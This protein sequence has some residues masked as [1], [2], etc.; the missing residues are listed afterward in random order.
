M[1]LDKMGTNN[2][3]IADAQ[4]NKFS[5]S[6]LFFWI[7]GSMLIDDNT[8]HIDMPNTAFFGLI[9]TG[10]KR[11][12]KEKIYHFKQFLMFQLIIM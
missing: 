1:S 11:V 3:S 4:G 10:K 8:I 12:K 6:L 9:P 5:V 2:R 7:K